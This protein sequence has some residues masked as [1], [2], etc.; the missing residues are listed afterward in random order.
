MNTLRIAIALAAA[1]PLAVVAH[2]AE[3]DQ[4]TTGVVYDDL[5]LASDAGKA[6]LNRRID[7]A[8][9]LVCGLGESTVGT[10]IRTREARTCYDD[11]RRAL[12]NHFAGI[13]RNASRGG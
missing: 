5:D 10:R 4:R 9:K 13:L 6:E 3:T 8:A 11:A 2:A 12:D 7:R 1:L